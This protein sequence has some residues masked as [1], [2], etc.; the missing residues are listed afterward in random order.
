MRKKTNKKT[1]IGRQGTTIGESSLQCGCAATWGSSHY[2]WK[3]DFQ[4]SLIQD[5][6]LGKQLPERVDAERFIWQFPFGVG[7]D[8]FSLNVFCDEANCRKLG[9]SEHECQSGKINVF[10]RRRCLISIASIFKF[11]VLLSSMSMI[12]RRTEKMASYP[13]NRIQSYQ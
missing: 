1:L 2:W 13:V 6:E 3:N 12:A 8:H 7:I 9:S 11:R 10:F 4:N 5:I